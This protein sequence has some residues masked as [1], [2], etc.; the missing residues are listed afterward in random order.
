MIMYSVASARALEVVM[1]AATTAMGSMA[2]LCLPPIPGAKVAGNVVPFTISKAWVLGR[3]VARA[4]DAK[5]D[6][7]AAVVDVA[8]GRLMFRGKVTDVL[9]F[10]GGGFNKGVVTIAAMPHDSTF[11]GETVKVDVQNENLLLRRPDWTV[12]AATPDLITI[13]DTQTGRSIFTEDMRYGMRV[14][15]IVMPIHPLM[16]TKSA[17]KVCSPK[18]FGYDDVTYE[19][20]E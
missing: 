16:N 10:A 17:L 13:L 1:R 15:V 9:R 4:Q 20:A 2:G 12:V 11:G 3:A 6:P 14:S 18:A 19:P 7:V 5:V 8:E